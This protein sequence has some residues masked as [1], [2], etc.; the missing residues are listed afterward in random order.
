M[1][2][3]TIKSLNSK[4]HK[5]HAKTQLTLV[6]NTWKNHCS[7]I[8]HFFATLLIANRRADKIEQS[9]TE[10]FRTFFMNCRQFTKFRVQTNCDVVEC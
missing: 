9:G 5:N 8:I 6:N 4:E 10:S 2:W 7:I 3:A 1:K